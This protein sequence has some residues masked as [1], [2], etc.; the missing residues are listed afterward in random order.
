MDERSDFRKNNRL[1]EFDYSQPAMYFVTIC[2]HDRA[3]LFGAGGEGAIRLSSFGRIVQD[4]W[5]EIPAHY[6]GVL[7]DAVVVMPNHVHGIL[8]LTQILVGAR[9][10]SPT[11]PSSAT[12]RRPSL[13]SIVGSFKSAV[14]SRI[15]AARGTPSAPVWQRNYHEHVIRSDEDL[16]R[17][18]QYIADNPLKWHLDRENPDRVAV[19]LDQH[20][21]N[22]RSS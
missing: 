17:A 22:D 21:S 12:K 2:A 5:N 9:H 18:R 3:M 14:T 1:R 19:R 7:T 6:P 15:N 16:R 4:C 10:A 11:A 20:R 13:G 8:D